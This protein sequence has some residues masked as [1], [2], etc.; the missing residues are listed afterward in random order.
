MDERAS[1][2]FKLNFVN[3][4]EINLFE[5][6]LNCGKCMIKT[7]FKIKGVSDYLY[8]QSYAMHLDLSS[9]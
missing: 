3:V 9:K 8:S 6:K 4:L 2:Q 5:Q 7:A 1:G